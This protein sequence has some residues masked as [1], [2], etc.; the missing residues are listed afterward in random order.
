VAH[1]GENTNEE[2]YQQEPK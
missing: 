1:N 2:E